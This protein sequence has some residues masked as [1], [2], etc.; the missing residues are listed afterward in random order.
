MLQIYFPL[1]GVEF[2]LQ[3]LL[4]TAAAI[5][6]HDE[7]FVLFCLQLIFSCEQ[8]LFIDFFFILTFT[9]FR[10]QRGAVP[11]A[12]WAFLRNRQMFLT[13]HYEPQN[14]KKKNSLFSVYFGLVFVIITCCSLVE[15]SG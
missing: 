10:K 5:I 9:L 7:S 1:A 14:K 6:S 15:L 4:L 3:Y 13:E 12:V 11:S 8:S 2:N